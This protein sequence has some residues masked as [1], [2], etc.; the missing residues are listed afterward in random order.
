MWERTRT[1]T[2]MTLD[3]ALR[4]THLLGSLLVTRDMILSSPISD[5]LGQPLQSPPGQSLESPPVYALA[6]VSIHPPGSSV[7]L[8]GHITFAKWSGWAAESLLQKLERNYPFGLEN[9]CH[10]WPSWISSYR[11]DAS[12]VTQ[13]PV[14]L[15]GPLSMKTDLI[16]ECVLSQYLELFQN[17]LC[18]VVDYNPIRRQDFHITLDTAWFLAP[19][20]SFDVRPPASLLGML[21]SSD[22]ERFWS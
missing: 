20:T 19:T 13:M 14:G 8:L 15:R 16:P 21:W 3:S 2:R 5:R 17:R 6:R 11:L 7:V 12:S 1:W 4:E 9:F 10:D 18:E 22:G